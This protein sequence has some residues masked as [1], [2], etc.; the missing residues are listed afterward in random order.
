MCWTANQEVQGSN[1]G[2]G[3]NSFYSGSNTDYMSSEPLKTLVM[4]CYDA[5]DYMPELF[6]YLNNTILKYHGNVL[7][8]IIC[9]T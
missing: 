6:K 4:L 3:S 2:Q 5:V 7:G 9:W 1:P 8:R